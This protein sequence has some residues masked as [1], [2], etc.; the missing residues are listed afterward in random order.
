MV[1]VI[2]ARHAAAWAE[3]DH[4]NAALDLAHISLAALVSRWWV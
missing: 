3:A 2:L 4:S 1:S